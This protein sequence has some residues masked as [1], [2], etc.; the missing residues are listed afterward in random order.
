LLVPA[1]ACAFG[2]RRCA[3]ILF[4]L[5]LATTTTAL[6]AGAATI[7][8]TLSALNS[9]NSGDYSTTGPRRE[10]RSMVTTEY[11]AADSFCVRFASV[12]A[13][14]VAAGGNTES[15]GSTSSYRITF[16]VQSTAPWTMKIWSWRK[17]EYTIL[18]DGGGRGS[19]AI[20]TPI[21]ATCNLGPLTPLQFPGG[22]GDNHS[23]DAN[24]IH[25][26]IHDPTA[27]TKAWALI[28]G[29]AGNTPV[30]LS[31]SWHDNVISDPDGAITGGDEAAVRLGMS[32]FGIGRCDAGDYEA[33]NDRV[34]ATDGHFVC[35]K[36]CEPPKV[37]ISGA[38]YCS[39][40]DNSTCSFAAAG[41]VLGCLGNCY[42]VVCKFYNKNGALVQT[43]TT[44]VT[45][46]SKSWV[47]ASSGPGPCSG[48]PYTME[49]TLVDDACAITSESI[50]ADLVDELPHTTVDVVMS[51]ACA[52]TGGSVNMPST[53]LWGRISVGLSLLAAGAFLIRR[54]YARSS[55]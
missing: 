35:A 3:T 2:G 37:S 4:L 12:L 6:N 38:S 44:S 32:T 25:A 54:R 1:R 19:A 36:L 52:G 34:K 14:D 45:N 11:N 20:V 42:T 48:D 43:A 13:C 16:T 17:G 26:S 41:T 7:V 29:P 47:A 30:T 21:T 27:T 31:F 15:E 9:D 23:N 28:G 55:G 33:L 40:L 10:R 51:T 22:S 46:G 49:T 39:A 18:S 53:T 50:L 8:G 5:F 24:N